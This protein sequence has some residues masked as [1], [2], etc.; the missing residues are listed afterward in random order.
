MTTRADIVREARTWIGTR[1]HHQGR[2]KG[3]GCD[4]AGLVIGVANALGIA[5]YQEPATYGRRPSG[6]DMQFECARNL[7]LRPV[8]ELR[9]GNVALMAFGD[10]PQHLAIVSDLEPGGGLIHCYTQVRRCVEH[11]LTAEWK[12]RIRTVYSYRGID[13]C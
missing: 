5:D 4:C 1:F 9:P 8:G 7:D 6:F 3:V 13:E 12:A 2:L 11:H 10:Y